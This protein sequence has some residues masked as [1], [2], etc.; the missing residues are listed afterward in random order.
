[1]G[2]GLQQNNCAAAVLEEASIK[3]PLDLKKNYLEK[4]KEKKNIRLE[5]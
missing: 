3:L 5:F 1:M 2:K 4:E